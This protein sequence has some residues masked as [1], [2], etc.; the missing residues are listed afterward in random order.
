[1]GYH[2]AKRGRYWWIYGRVKGA[3]L[4]SSLRTT[5]KAEAE[6]IAKEKVRR[7]LERAHGVRVIRNVKFGEL[8]AKYLEYCEQNNRPS[9]Y[10]K[11]QDLARYVLDYFGDVSLSVITT[12]RIE[13]FK[14]AR[15]RKL[16]PASVNREMAL[17]KHALNLAVEWDY[18]EA[19]PAARVKKFKEPPGRVRY[20]TRD[21]AAALI[22]AC[23]AN[24]RPIVLMALH[25]GM[26]RGEIL[27]LDWEHVD[28]KR[29]QLRVVD[30]KNNE[31]RVVPIN[32][33]LYNCVRALPVGR[34]KVFTSRRGRAYVTIRKGFEAAVKTA[35][36]KG[37][38]FHDL[39]HT[40][41]S[42]LAMEGVPLSTIGRLLGHKT[43]QMTMRY[44]HLA[45]EYLA[46]VVEL[47]TQNEHSRKSGNGTD[48]VS[49]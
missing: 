35:G 24:I 5:V 13:G 14:A 31:S 11:K 46:D 20:L 22:K 18:L 8:L 37:F 3:R 33:I 32:E 26:R 10:R 9:T 23:P 41:A 42:W 47:L 27:S 49:S 16:A 19:S 4:D 21:E 39:R 30:T 1:M 48:N 36:I 44:A 15:R 34:G 40:F 29:R 2:I 7:A 25:T 28:L 12:E 38:T 43:P 45:P 6:A 17:L